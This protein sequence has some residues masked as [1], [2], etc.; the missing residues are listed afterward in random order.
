MLIVASRPPNQDERVGEYPLVASSFNLIAFHY[1]PAVNDG[2][3]LVDRQRFALRTAGAGCCSCDRRFAVEATED[4]GTPT[5][6]RTAGDAR[7][8]PVRRHGRYERAMRADYQV[9]G[10]VR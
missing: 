5:R 7:V 8:P 3:V 10:S 1:P 4:G 9:E 6:F 2:G